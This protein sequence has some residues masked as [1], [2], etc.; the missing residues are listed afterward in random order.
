MSTDPVVPESSAEDWLDAIAV[1]RQLADAGQPRRAVSELEQISVQIPND[2]VVL[3]A[4]TEAFG[5]LGRFEEA[6]AALERA[7]ELDPRGASVAATRGILMFRR[8]LYEEAEA[9]LREVCAAN[10]EHA[11]AHYYRGEALNRIGRVDEAI[12][13]LQVATRLAP[14]D[15]R[16]YHT[17]GRLYDRKGQP[18]TAAGMYR[19]ARGLDGS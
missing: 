5:H 3:V 19:I 4:L 14:S 8:G 1:A 18:D 17:L 6:D 16:A 13:V 7:V 15:A 11:A 9:Q 10:P 2:V 12:E